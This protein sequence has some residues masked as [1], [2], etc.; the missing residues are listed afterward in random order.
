MTILHLMVGL[1]CS[2]KSTRA[3]QLE[4]ELGALRL[5]PD[6]WHIALF[7]DDVA[8]PAHDRRHDAVEALMWRVAS[9]VLARGVD[10]ILDFG[11]W[12]RV[13]REDFAARAAALGATTTIH[14]MDVPRDELLARLTRRNEEAPEHAFIISAEDLLGWLARFE[15]VTAD[16]LA[17]IAAAGSRNQ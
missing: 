6:E 1:P 15:P 4:A 16:E 11:F 2:G 8:D 7:G 14:F 3:K 17:V 13:E 5:T 10:V 9:T 12:A